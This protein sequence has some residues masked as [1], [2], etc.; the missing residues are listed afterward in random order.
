MITQSINQLYYSEQFRQV[1]SVSVF[2][3]NWIY[4]NSTVPCAKFKYLLTLVVAVLFAALVMQLIKDIGVLL[5]KELEL[6]R[7]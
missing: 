7:Q 2:Q 1:T 4:L 5:F 6:Q 3:L